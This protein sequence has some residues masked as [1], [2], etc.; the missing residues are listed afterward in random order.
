MGFELIKNVIEGHHNYSLR[1]FLARIRGKYY[2]QRMIKEVNFS[3]QKP[4]SPLVNSGDFG[5][6]RF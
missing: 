2:L 1:H 4:K 5:E 6:K 3:L